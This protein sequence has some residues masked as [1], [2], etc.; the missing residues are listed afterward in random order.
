MADADALEQWRLKQGWPSGE[1]RLTGDTNPFELG[2]ARSVSL[3]KGCYLG[4]ETM[5]KL[6]AS[7]G[8]KQQLRSWSSTAAISTGTKLARSGERAGVV[9]SSLEV[10]T[11][12]RWIGLALVRRQHLQHAQLERSGGAMSGPSAPR[13]ISGP[14]FS[15]FLL[16]RIADLASATIQR[17][18]RSPGSH[19]G[20]NGR[21]NPVH[22]NCCPTLVAPSPCH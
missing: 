21:S 22:E 2:L 10:T 5:A 14:T 18:P 20:C 11:G 1:P 15:R 3:T 9:T 7:G 17:Q 4:Q 19:R 12:R 13:R 8:V 6:A 16:I